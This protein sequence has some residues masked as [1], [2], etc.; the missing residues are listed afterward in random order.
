LAHLPA[1][2]QPCAYH[3]SGDALQTIKSL[4]SSHLDFSWAERPKDRTT[5]TSLSPIGSPNLNCS[6]CV[7]CVLCT[8]VVENGGKHS[9]LR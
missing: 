9:P 6:L 2:A 7:L 5:R 4:F 3:Q 1:C 8:S